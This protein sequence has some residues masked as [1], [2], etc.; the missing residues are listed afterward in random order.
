[1]MTDTIVSD[2]YD[3]FFGD[4]LNSLSPED[5]LF[6]N[7]I[8]FTDFNNNSQSTSPVQTITT[9][10]TENDFDPAMFERIVNELFSSDPTMLKEQSIDLA[11]PLFE[12]ESTTREI[13]TDPMEPSIPP[14]TL[15]IIIKTTDTNQ[16]TSKPIILIQTTQ[17]TKPIDV[18]NDYFSM[19]T[20]YLMDD[21]LP[22]TP[23]TSSDSPDERNSNSPDSIH[24]SS[25]SAMFTDLEHLPSSG[26][27]VL[28]NEEVKLIK[29]EGYQVPTRLPL[30]KTEERMLKKIRRKIKNK[31]SA[32]ESRRKKKEYVDA[33]EKEIAK[34]V[35]ENK[36][37]K[38]RMATIEKSQKALAKERDLLRTMVGKNLPTPTQ[39]TAL[40]VF[41]VFFAV[42]F[43]AW[44]PLANKTSI[45][46]RALS[47]LP[48]H[49]YQS[50]AT[51]DQSLYKQPNSIQSEGHRSRVLLSVDDYE[52]Y[53]HGPYLPSNNKYK[54]SIHPQIAAPGYTYSD[55]V[56]KYMNKKIQKDLKRSST[57]SDDDDVEESDM[58]TIKKFRPDI[59][60][61]FVIIEEINSDNHENK[62]V[63][64]IRVERTVPSMN[65][66]TLKLAHRE[67]NA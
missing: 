6:S 63:K 30:N 52:Q 57:A 7:E 32:Q 46:D 21:P 61:N 22:L 29:Q 39:G 23:S 51:A 18:Q 60:E 28:T 36:A 43:G 2:P 26:K 4:E 5:L 38:Q 37:L 47:L 49:N 25:S 15:P 58:K 64:I 3:L 9:E 27:L 67:I 40:M 66:D 44:S 19:S 54:S 33:L 14:T 13:G 48:S 10:I 17:T 35:D 56:E 53:H 20:D 65:N 11:Y 24:E 16:L 50:V 8:M 59:N 62:S 34:Y 45:D 41:A 55:T 42:L 12:T 31:I 1:M